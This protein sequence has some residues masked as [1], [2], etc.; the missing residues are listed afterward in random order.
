M[1]VKTDYVGAK[2]KTYETDV[3]WRHAMNFA[4]AIDDANPRY[5]D[6][7]RD[8]G[9]V[10]PPMIAT[11]LTWPVSLNIG[12]Y[13]IAD[14]FPA[15]LNV[16]QVHYTETLEWHRPIV[17]GKKLRIEGELAALIN[18]PAG[19]HM[20]MKYDAFDPDGALIFREYT[21]AMLRG[22][23]T[24]GP[25]MGKDAVPMGKKYAAS[26]DPLWVERIAIGPLAAHI[27][28]GC[29]DIS[30]PIHTS[31][32]FAKSVGLPGIILHGTATLSMALRELINREGGA[33][34]DRMKVL[35][36]HFTDMVIPGTFIDVRLLGKEAGDGGD[37]LYFE[38]LNDKGNRAISRGRLRIARP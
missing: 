15:H 35:D 30:F 36:C 31:P 17:P 7:E 26:G 13:L 4:A 19:T 29:G 23:K 25:S 24:E 18:H 10:A 11:S 33:D 5:F 6:D 38:V 20:V 37:D 1:Y 2:T 16:N 14:G 32:K 8:G 22:V 27:Y 21:G 28:D 12:E 34:P 3:T 9:I